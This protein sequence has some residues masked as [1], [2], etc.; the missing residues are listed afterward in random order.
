MKI[1]RLTNPLNLTLS[2]RERGISKQRGLQGGSPWVS[3]A[4]MRDP[5]HP[6][7]F[8]Q[9]RPNPLPKGE[10]I[11][12]AMT[13][14][15]VC[16]PIVYRKRRPEVPPFVKGVRGILLRFIPYMW[17]PAKAGMTSGAP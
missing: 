2:Q 13:L 11:F 6:F 8:A 16:R 1:A 12:V 7:G 17:N 9:D 15:T 3:Q 5:P 10:G 14:L 4:A